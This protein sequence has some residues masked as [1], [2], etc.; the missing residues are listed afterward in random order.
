MTRRA[1]LYP[2]QALLGFAVVFFLWILVFGDEIT[3]WANKGIADFGFTGLTALSLQNINLF[4]LI[5]VAIAVTAIAYG[6]GQ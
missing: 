6:G 4:I 3:Y 1:Q 2:L 5:A